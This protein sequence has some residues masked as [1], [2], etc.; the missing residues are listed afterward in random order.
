MRGHHVLTLKSPPL[1]DTAALHVDI[2]V[3]TSSLGDTLPIIQ[4]TSRPSLPLES[5]SH[6][7]PTPRLCK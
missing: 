7:Q 3:M 4:K 1:D 5:P 2:L 6:H